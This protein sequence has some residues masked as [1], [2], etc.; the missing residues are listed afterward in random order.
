[1]LT[2]DQINALR[3][4]AQKITDPITEYLLQDL[5]RRIAEA[6]QLTSTAQYQVW[7]M[8]TLGVSQRQIKR[9]LRRLLKLSHRE[10]RKIMYQSAQSG[11]ELDV[12]R[13]PQ[14]QAI[15]F[16]QHIAL[17]QIVSAAVELAENDFTNLTQT[18]GMVDPYGSAL[19]FQD[20]YRSCTDFAFKQVIT[21]AA[22]YTEAI[23]QATRYL[24]DKG[25]R[26]IDYRS[27]VHT[28]L[29]AAVRRNIMGGLGLM[30][31]KISQVVHDD[32]ECDGW[33][34]TAHANSAP[35]HEPIQGKQYPDAEYQALN[36]SLVRRIGTLNCGHAAFPIIL[37]VNRPQY[38]HEE[39]EKLRADNEKGVTVEGVHYTGYQATQVQRKLERAIRA[40]KRR[41]MVGAGERLKQDKTRLTMLRQR[42]REFSKAAGL[43]TQYERTEVAGFGGEP[44][45]SLANPAYSGIIEPNR[46]EEIPEMRKT[47]ALVPLRAE[48][49]TEEYL[50]TA[51]PG[52]GAV[53]YGDGYKTKGHQDEIKIARWLYQT[54]GG[55]IRLLPEAI[56]RGIKMPDYL[57]NGKK[58]ELKG[59]HSISG[60]DKRLQYAIKQIKDNPGGVILDILA[61]VDMQKLERQIL[62]RF[63]R[64]EGI[65]T[66]DVMLVK[67]ENLLKILRHKK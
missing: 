47:S 35:D 26:T 32:L 18:L 51:T 20:A 48:D 34:I 39:L 7:R 21:G 56:D 17:Q 63:L 65:D 3:G 59:S 6:G 43:R 5:A 41:V 46:P 12:S 22:S 50:R 8:Q 60:A 31:E 36:D 61:D 11:Y 4:A 45:K 19:P 14:V 53:T 40:Q 23:R 54:F 30:Q 28:S 25:V 55:D 16:A 57:W 37:G 62:G 49:V 24:A 52:H 38:T 15:P 44:P 13:F 1:M 67:K 58:W 33:E 2:F 66:L 64:S 10:I 29:E 27:G 9:E 42:Y